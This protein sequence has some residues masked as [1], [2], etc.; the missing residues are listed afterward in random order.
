MPISTY[1]LIKHFSSHPD[2]SVFVILPETGEFYSKVK[3]LDVT[4]VAIKFYRIR[5]PKHVEAFLKFLFRL[6]RALAQVVSFL[7]R[8]NIAVA[9]FSDIIDFPFY[10]CAHFAGSK[11]L[12]HIRNAQYNAVTRLWYVWFLR[13]YVDQAICISRFIKSHY[14]LPD[15]FSRVIYN[16]GPDLTLFNRQKSYPAA[17]NFDSNKIIIGMVGKFLKIKG[18]RYFLDL[19]RIIESTL[20]GACRFIIVGNIET[21]HEAY[22]RF[23]HTYADNL[24]LSSILTISHD[25]HYERIPAFLSQMDIFIHMSVVPEGLGGVVLEAMSMGLA[26]VAFDSGGVGECFDNGKSGFLVP[27]KDIR[28]AAEK[29]SDLVQNPALRERLGL[30]ATFDLAKKFSYEK[31]FSEVE[32][33]YAERF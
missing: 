29:V 30:Q 16:P 20:P 3:A 18:H 14:S 10:P 11:A 27:R 25:A 9:H 13:R 12:A 6:P 33:L 22:S 19:A 31:H 26:I 2:Y 7:K 8:N 17:I 4:I 21:G 23:I 15:C 1:K 5:S 24:G 28:A 32:K